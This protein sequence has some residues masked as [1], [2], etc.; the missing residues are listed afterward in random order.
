MKSWL[1]MNI[2]SSTVV[3]RFSPLLLEE[4]E[5]CVWKSYVADYFKDGD[6]NK[7]QSG[8]LIIASLSVLFDRWRCAISDHSHSIAQGD[9]N[10]QGRRVAVTLRWLMIA[11]LVCDLNSNVVHSA[12]AT[13]LTELFMIQCNE[14]IKMKKR[15]IVILH[16]HLRMWVSWSR[17]FVCSQSFAWNTNRRIKTHYFSLKYA[18]AVDG[19]TEIH[20]FFA[21]FQEETTRFELKCVIANNLRDC[22]VI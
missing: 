11:Q 13:K 8:R 3:E 17:S 10:W 1:K 18:H 2:F 22:L 4:D 15:I 20:E 5:Y 7:R 21:I 9:T 12:T 14:T 19:L 6:A 16:T